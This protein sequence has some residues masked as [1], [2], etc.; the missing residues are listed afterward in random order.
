[1]GKSASLFTRREFIKQ[2]ATAVCAAPLVGS[3]G[4]WFGDNKPDPSDLKVYIFSKHLQ[5]LNYKD[6]S[7]AALEMGFDGVDLTVRPKGHVLPE[8]VTEDLPKA[9]EVMQSQGLETEM[10]TTKVLD[11]NN[12]LDKEVL[13]TVSAQGY[14]YYRMGWYRYKGEKP[15]LDLSKK[16][17][18]EL[19]A[20]AKLNAELG[21]S[22]A[23]HN[24]SGNYFGAGLWDLQQALQGVS[25]E[26][27]GCQFDIMHAT[28]EGGKSWDIGLRLM[29]EH[30]NTLVV[31]DFVWGR[32]SG[33]WKPQFV[34]L[35]EGM[36]DFPR[37]L[38]LLRKYGINVPVSIH[39]E[40]DLGGAE[41][42]GQPTIPHKD[43]F[44][45]LKKDLNFLRRSWEEAG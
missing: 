7:E 8:N 14:K 30:I 3:A 18:E 44:K 35:G 39:Y 31:K 19:R 4:A 36:V 23:Y 6:M 32:E 15:I 43:I 28:V 27:L 25:P 11:A 1:M 13:E 10:L 29:H 5:F 45:K 9:T 41:D 26:H 12:P 33:A 38:S 34:H 17:Q 42:G 20:L 22:G 40:Y 2:T 37:Y 16:Y 24:H 21:L